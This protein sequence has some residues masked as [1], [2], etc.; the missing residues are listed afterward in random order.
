MKPVTIT[1]ASPTASVKKTTV[2]SN[3][4]TVVL[5]EQY[6]DGTTKVNTGTFT[7]SRLDKVQVALRHGGDRVLFAAAFTLAYVFNGDLSIYPL[8]KRKTDDGK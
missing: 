2:S 3:E 8:R 1:G 4:L 5:T 7:I 6:S